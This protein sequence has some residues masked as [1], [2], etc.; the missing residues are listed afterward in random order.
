[1]ENKKPQITIRE[2]MDTKDTEIFWAQLHAYLKRDILPNPDDEDLEYFLGEEYRTHIQEVHD[3]HEDRLHYLFFCWDGEDIGFAMPVIFSTEDGKCF[4]MEFCVY[5]E[6]RGNGTGHQCAR[7]LLDWSKQNGATYAELNYGSNERRL[8]FWKS[9]GFVANGADQWGDPLLIYPPKEFVPY[10]VE[11][12]TDPTDWQLIKLE[13][14]LLAEIGEKPMTE[15][16]QRQLQGTIQNGDI[17]VFFARRSYRAV[18]M[19]SI[20]KGCSTSGCSDTGVLEHLY[21]E[22]AFRKKGIA[23]MLVEA[24]HTWSHAHGMPRLVGTCGFYNETKNKEH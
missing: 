10:S 21:V 20:A 5:P 12:L 22:P 19:C 3:R 15:K 14:G 9:M 16:A 2:A 23:R 17:T 18:G 4:I 8:R 7:A 1:M 11:I 24:A 6:F 13:N